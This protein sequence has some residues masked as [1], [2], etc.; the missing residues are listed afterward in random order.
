M[1]INAI[2]QDIIDRLKANLFLAPEGGEALPALEVAPFPDRPDGYQLTHPL[3]A[4]LVSYWGARYGKPRSVGPIVQT[5]SPEFR[6]W[7]MTKDLR[8]H[9]GAYRY[10]DAV[11]II[12]TGHR[13]PDGGP[14]YPVRDGYERRRGNTWW[15]S[16][17]FACDGVNIEEIEAEQLVTVTQITYTNATTGRSVVVEVGNGEE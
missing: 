12:M 16:I 6:V 13:P 11:R 9:A 5:R 1:Q 7:V 15:H 10:L 17:S 4:V 8:T 2:E 14:L 3:G